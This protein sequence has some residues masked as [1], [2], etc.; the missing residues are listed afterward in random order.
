VRL[1]LEG[2]GRFAGVTRDIT[3]SG[4]TQ[5]RIADY[6]SYTSGLYAMEAVLLSGGAEVCT[7]P[8]NANL[9]IDES[10]PLTVGSQI[11]AVATG[12]LAAASAAASAQ[13]V[14]VNLRMKVALQRRRPTGLR[15]WLP[16]PAW[17]RTIINMFIGALVGVSITVVLQQRGVYPLSLVSAIWGAV[18]GGGV[19]FGVGYSIGALITY[20]R[21]PVPPPATPSQP[22]PSGG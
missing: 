8:F 3:G 21:P 4:V 22:P 5:I 6:I 16:V 11:A 12:V 9:G 2:F 18:L 1:S 15:R 14:V 7:L 13:G 19:T 17:K 10:S 20:L